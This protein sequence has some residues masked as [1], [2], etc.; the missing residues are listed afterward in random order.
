MD[1]ASGDLPTPIFF[2]SYV[3][4]DDRHEWH[5]LQ[6]FFHDLSA[7]VRHL[8]PEAASADVGFLDLP[9]DG[10]DGW[11][12][13][14]AGAVATCQVFVPLV[15]PDYF[16]SDW[17]TREWEV[18]SRRRTRESSG[19]AAGGILPVLWTPAATGPAAADRPAAVDLVGAPRGLRGLLRD[20]HRR[21]E[22]HAAVGALAR[23]I[24]DVVALHEPSP[25]GGEVPP[26]P[27]GPL[28][29]GAGGVGIR[30]PGGAVPLLAGP[31]SPTAFR[32][33]V[34]LSY[35]HA[36]QSY[37][38]RLALYLSSHGLAV[39]YDD[40][41]TCGDQFEKVIQRRIEDCSAFVVVL[42]PDALESDW[43]ERE[44]SYAV[45]M[46]KPIHPLMLSRCE[47]PFLIHNVHCE[48]VL[49]GRMP[50]DRFIAA[51]R[52]SGGPGRLLRPSA[53]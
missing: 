52:D 25:L 40:E 7:E 44:T 27:L 4:S 37:V 6:R 45:K 5:S 31:S 38:D 8:L 29:S 19:V 10:G 23:R 11:T 35:S 50:S 43:V 24:V 12:E 34:F 32:R 20:R 1:P 9:L 33:P 21:G 18:F 3:R 16:N 42:S 26:P 48:M 46:R 53:A 17:C 49:D 22:Y 2:L 39:W 51:V 47:L 36:N 30:R 15:S 14:V 41:L 13:R 28:L